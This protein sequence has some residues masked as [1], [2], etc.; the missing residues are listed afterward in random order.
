MDRLM[1][2]VDYP[3][4]ETAKGQKFLSEVAVAPVD[5]EKLKGG[6]AGKLREVAV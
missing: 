5:I 4:S 6:N 3:F 2:S 1:D